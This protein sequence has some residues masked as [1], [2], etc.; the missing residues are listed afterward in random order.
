LK[1]EGDN[2]QQPSHHR[3]SASIDDE[4][5]EGAFK[6][7]NNLRLCLH[8]L[9]FINKTCILLNRHYRQSYQLV[10]VCF[11]ELEQ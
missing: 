3:L 6:I 2:N 8:L 5:R 7:I 11:P 10:V 4:E 1:T 9:A